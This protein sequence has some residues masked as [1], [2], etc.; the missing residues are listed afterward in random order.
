MSG[1]TACRSIAILLS[2]GPPPTWLGLRT[3]LPCSAKTCLTHCM[4]RWASGGGAWAATCKK[5]EGDVSE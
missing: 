5:K 3:M 1:G 4:M 2:R